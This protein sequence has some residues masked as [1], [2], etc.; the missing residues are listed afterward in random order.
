[1][2]YLADLYVSGTNQIRNDANHDVDLSK[3]LRFLDKCLKVIIV[4][5]ELKIL[6]EKIEVLL[7]KLSN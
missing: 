7:K 4:F 3:D 2:H 6:N 1:M 5:Q